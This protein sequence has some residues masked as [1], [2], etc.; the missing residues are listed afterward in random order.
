MTSARHGPPERCQNRSQETSRSED[1]PARRRGTA[2]PA[3][4]T[5]GAL[6]DLV[7]A[8]YRANGQKSLKETKARI[9]NGL[10]PYLG[11]MPAD[12]LGTDHIESWMAWREN[13]RMYKSVKHGYVKLQQ[14]TINRELSLLRRAY[15]LGYERK[16][17]LVERIPL[18]KKL[19]ENNVR[20]RIRRTRAVP[21]AHRGI[22]RH[23]SSQL[24][25]S[26]FTSLIGR[27][28]CSTWN[29]RMS[30]CTGILR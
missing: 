16:P 6:L 29:G 13:H 24:R 17:Q 26:P 11:D 18:I 23:I 21:K 7:I 15:Q 1:V 27:A 20:K 5:L 3:Q 9:E 28:G 14:A 10:R 30:T 25:A 12:K 8:D 19:A 2:K 22:V 4:V